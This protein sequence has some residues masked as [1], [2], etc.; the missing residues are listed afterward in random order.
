MRATALVGQVEARVS[1]LVPKRRTW[2][3]TTFTWV[4]RRMDTGPWWNRKI[5]QFFVNQRSGTGKAAKETV[6]GVWENVYKSIMGTTRA[7]HGPLSK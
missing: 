4:G 5:T 1:E 7:A 6:P 2:P 3:P